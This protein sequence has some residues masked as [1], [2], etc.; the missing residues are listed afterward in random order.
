MFIILSF[1]A[2]NMVNLSGYRFYLWLFVQYYSVRYICHLL[3]VPVFYYFVTMVSKISH[4]VS[5]GLFRIHG[6]FWVLCICCKY[7][8][9]YFPLVL[10]WVHID[11]GILFSN[12]KIIH[13]RVKCPKS[14]FTKE[15]RTYSCIPF[16][17]S[18]GTC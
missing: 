16:N 18:S 12:C 15:N 3:Y 5:L 9:T 4:W 7:F 2:R 10:Y 6:N 1:L 14:R 17:N 11:L 8:M 13:D